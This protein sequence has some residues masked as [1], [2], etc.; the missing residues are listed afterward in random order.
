MKSPKNRL[1]RARARH[2]NTLKTKKALNYWAYNFLGDVHRK[3]K[4]KK[5]LRGET[6]F[7]GGVS[8]REFVYLSLSR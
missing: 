2:P 1:K 6:F 8:R 4:E 7:T 3:R 5:Q